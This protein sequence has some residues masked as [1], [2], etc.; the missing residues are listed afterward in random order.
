MPSKVTQQDTIM[1]HLQNVGAISQIEAAS[2]YNVWRLAAVIHRLRQRGHVINKTLVAH[3]AGGKYA[4][5]RLEGAL[6][7]PQ[8]NMHITVP[9]TDTSPENRQTASLTLDQLKKE[10]NP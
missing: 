6:G 9:K 3:K 2:R 4:V 10:L 8:N 5:Y 7:S 1:H